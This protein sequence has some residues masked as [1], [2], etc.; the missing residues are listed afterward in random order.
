M[1]LFDWAA[2]CSEE[3]SHKSKNI[4]LHKSIKYSYF[5]SFS[6]FGEENKKCQ[7]LNFTGPEF[8]SLR[9]THWR[10]SYKDSNISSPN[11]LKVTQLHR[12]FA[13]IKKNHGPYEPSVCGSI[14][15]FGHVWKIKAENLCLRCLGENYW[16]ALAISILLTS[17][18][19]KKHGPLK[20]K[21]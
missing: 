5:W 11:F 12:A 10:S 16:N 20:I 4:M 9:Q 14:S 21:N 8:F 1:S 6:D 3:N 2:C 19:V 17:K 18:I 13:H 7:K 15:A